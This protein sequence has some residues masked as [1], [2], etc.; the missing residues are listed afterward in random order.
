[1]IDKLLNFFKKYIA[2]I[3]VTLG[4]VVICITTFNVNIIAG[5]YTTGGI[6][7]ASGL[8]IASGR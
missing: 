8:L 5:L 6:L 3:L 7:F 1:M 4:M 2:E